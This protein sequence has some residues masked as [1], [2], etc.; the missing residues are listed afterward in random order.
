MLRKFVGDTGVR[1]IDRYLYSL[2]RLALFPP[3]P[4]EIK[5]ATSFCWLMVW[6]GWCG[7]VLDGIPITTCNKYHD[8]K[9]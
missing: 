2:I 4:E 9:A 7:W 3:I 1:Y 8:I 6:C 5:D